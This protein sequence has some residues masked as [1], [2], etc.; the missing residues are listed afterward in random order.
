MAIKKVILGSESELKLRAVTRALNGL[1]V[2]SETIGYKTGSGV[3]VQPQGMREIFRGATNRAMMVRGAYP[4]ADLWIGIESG[5]VCEFACWYDLAGVVVVGPGGKSTSSC[6][7]HFP[8]PSWM[9]AR[10]LLKETDLGNVVKDLVGGG[11]KDPMVWLSNS[12]IFREHLIDQAVRCALM[13]ILYPENYQEPV[14]GE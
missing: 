9:V 1:G 3:S 4:D 11:E 14:P 12:A 5:I 2:H 7:A 13:E 6:S 10:A 8:I